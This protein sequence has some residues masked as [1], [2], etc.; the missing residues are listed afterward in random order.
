MVATEHG[1]PLLQGND[2]IP[3]ATVTFCGQ[4]FSVGPGVLAPRPETE[5]LALSALDLI[6]GVAAPQV[7]DMC[8]GAGN[9]GVTLA[10]RRPAARV[11][12]ADLTPSACAFARRNVDVLGVGDRVTVHQGD[13]FAAVA[14]VVPEGGVDLVVA[15][16]P[17]ISTGRLAGDSAHLLAREPREAFDGGPYGLSIHQRLVREASA[18]L[19]PG[20]ALAFEFG[21]GQRAQIERLLARAGSWT[22]VVFQCDAAGEPRVATARFRGDG[23]GR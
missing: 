18:Y 15:N 8:C 13:L 7:I 21:L 23:G 12:A 14:G 19:K 3:A 11:W 16:P 5:L 17:Y 1:E 20:G 6:A 22:D 4:P 2:A 10:L 9:I